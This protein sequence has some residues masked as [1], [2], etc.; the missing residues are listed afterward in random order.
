MRLMP[1]PEVD[2]VIPRGF[3]ATRLDD[4]H[5]VLHRSS[6]LSRAGSFFVSRSQWPWRI[7]RLMYR[8]GIRLYGIDYGRSRVPPY[9][10]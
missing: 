8:I 5:W 1:P 2:A 7:G 6:W 4:E 3:T 10:A 9:E